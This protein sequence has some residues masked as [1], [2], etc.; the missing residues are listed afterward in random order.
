MGLTTTIAP[1]RF[2]LD[3]YEDETGVSGTGIV[4]EGVQFAD[5]TCVTHWCASEIHQTCVWA[6]I[7]HVKRIHGHDGKTEVRWLDQGHTAVPPIR[8][9]WYWCR[10]HERPHARQIEAGCA[11]VGPFYSPAEASEWA[12]GVGMEVEDG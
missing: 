2:V 9:A 5:G 6:S 11:L 8:G 7:S 12:R 10:T 4:A 3:R 1:R